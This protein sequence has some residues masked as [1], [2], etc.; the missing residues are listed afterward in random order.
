MLRN[1][2]VKEKSIWN[3]RIVKETFF[4]TLFFLPTHLWQHSCS[5]CCHLAFVTDQSHRGMCPCSLQ[6][7]ARCQLEQSQHIWCS[8]T[9]CFHSA[10]I[11]KQSSGRSR[12]MSDWCEQ[13][14]KSQVLQLLS[15]YWAAKCLTFVQNCANIL[16]MKVWNSLATHNLKTKW[17]EGQD[18]K[19]T[20]HFVKN[21]KKKKKENIYFP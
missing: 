21:I 2:S 4:F 11:I 7:A 19:S 1:T 8:E 6:T 13:R 17:H 9:A 3:L 5:I 16:N 15:S 14:E 12:G 18:L 20:I 10:P